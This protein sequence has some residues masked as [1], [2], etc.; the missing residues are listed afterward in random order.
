MIPDLWQKALI[1]IHEEIINS[2]VE[3][4]WVEETAQQLIKDFNMLGHHVELKPLKIDKYADLFQLATTKIKYLYENEYEVFLNLIYR[5][6][7][8]E[9]QLNALIQAVAP[10]Q[11]YEKITEVVLK[12]EFIKVFL[13]YRYNK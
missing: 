3:V 9:T 5:I 8:D 11:L 13:R 2:S 10:P 12:R 1:N 6:D 4:D 7:L